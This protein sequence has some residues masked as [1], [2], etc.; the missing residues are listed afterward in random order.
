[1]A[2]EKP[3]PPDNVFQQ[4]LDNA[5]AIRQARQRETRLIKEE[6]AQRPERQI[7]VYPKHSRGADDT[8]IP[9]PYERKQYITKLLK[10]LID[11]E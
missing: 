4:I 6:M 7:P 3:F 8:S 2:T 9:I 11:E 5:Q 10:D 1:M